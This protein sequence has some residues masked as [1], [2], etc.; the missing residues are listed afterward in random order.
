MQA[1]IDDD[2]AA[3]ENIVNKFDDVISQCNPIEDPQNCNYERNRA[4]PKPQPPPMRKELQDIIDDIDQ[5]Q[6]IE[7]D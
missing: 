1:I 6:N 2:E 5:N 3:I 7:G 4:A